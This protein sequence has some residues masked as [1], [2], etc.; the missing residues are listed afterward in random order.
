VGLPLTEQEI[1]ALIGTSRQTVSG[2]L[3]EMIRAG[4]VVRRARELVV[5]D[6]RPLRQ[7][8]GV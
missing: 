3:D 7:V 5:A 1:A 4:L 8:A 2:A 6:P